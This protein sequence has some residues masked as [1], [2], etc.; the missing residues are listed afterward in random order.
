MQWDYDGAF[1]KEFQKNQVSDHLTLISFV[2]YAEVR[3]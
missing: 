3:T 2:G 1:G